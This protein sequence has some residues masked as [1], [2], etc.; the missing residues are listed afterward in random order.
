MG[1]NKSRLLVVGILI[2]AGVLTAI[3][4]IG[5][6]SSSHQSEQDLVRPPA[7]AGSWYPSDPAELRE[8]IDGLIASVRGPDLQGEL[9]ALIVPHAGYQYSGK[10]AALGYSCIGGQQFSRVVILAPTHAYYVAG[11]SVPSYT[12]FRTP[13]GDVPVDTTACAELRKNKLLK[14]INAAHAEEHSIEIQLPF[15]QRTLENFSIVPILVGSVD[16]NDVKQIAAAVKPLLDD[17]TLLLVSSDFTHYGSRFSYRPFTTDVENKLH[18]L[19]YGAF[20]HILAGDPDGFLKYRDETGITACGAMPI[21]ILLE[22]LGADTQSMLLTYLTSGR[23]TGDWS[24][25]VSYASFCF[26]KK[27]ELLNEDEQQTLLRLSRDVLS[28]FTTNGGEPPISFERYNITPAMLRQAGVFVTLRKKGDLRGCIGSIVGVAPI[29]AEVIDKTKSAAAQDPRFRPVTAAEASDLSIEISV[30]TPLRRINDYRTIKLGTDGVVLKKGQFSGV[31]LPIVA[32][33]TGWSLD[34][35]MNNLCLK[36]GLRPGAHT[37][38]GAEI[39]CFQVQLF[40][41]EEPKPN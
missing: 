19:D 31:F 25:S 28:T 26:T 36:A 32:E 15:L 33:E 22:A 10:V 17:K 4:L 37:E 2:F 23:L 3:L 16:K 14:E 7:L 40:S 34:E 30:L 35:F 21:A 38:P 39:Y 20:S 29:V 11:C 24:N 27:R 41:E 5:G 6:V 18:S 12:A 1:N 8:T 9:R 13:L